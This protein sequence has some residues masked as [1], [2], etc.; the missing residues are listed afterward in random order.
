MTE[1]DI[2]LALAINQE[3]AASRKKYR[4]NANL[5][6]ALLAEAGELA[7]AQL[8]SA[9]RDQVRQEAIQVIAVAL[10]ILFEGDSSIPFVALVE[11]GPKVESEE[12]RT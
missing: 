7:A 12:R 8:K 1:L 6:T 2:P 3:L 9:G 10:R 5:T 4:G 11:P